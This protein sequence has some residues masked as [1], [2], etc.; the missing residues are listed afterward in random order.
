LVDMFPPKTVVIRTDP[1]EYLTDPIEYLSADIHS[2]IYST[3][4]FKVL[5]SSFYFIYK[6]LVKF[7]REMWKR[8]IFMEL[9]MLINHA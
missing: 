7:L 1:I 5:V 3:L 9:N 8:K 2:R 4:N 6:I